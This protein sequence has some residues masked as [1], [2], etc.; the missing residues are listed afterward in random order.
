MLYRKNK[1]LGFLSFFECIRTFTFVFAGISQ[2][3]LLSASSVGC[4]AEHR[5]TNSITS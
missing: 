4:H 2:S 1:V 5:S 3:N